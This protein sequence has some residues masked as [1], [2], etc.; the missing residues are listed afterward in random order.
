MSEAKIAS[1]AKVRAL[2]CLLAEC[3]GRMMPEAFLNAVVASAETL[4]RFESRAVHVDRRTLSMTPMRNDDALAALCERFS[5]DVNRYE[6]AVARELEATKKPSL[7]VLMMPGSG[8][9]NEDCG[10]YADCLS[11]FARAY[12]GE[13]RC[14]SKCSSWAQAHS[15][16]NS[17]SK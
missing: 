9:R 7:P 13:G 17:E 3:Q 16:S 12:S 8:H 10:L 14:P 5:E 4:A 1:A 2:E 6:Q 11:A 15:V